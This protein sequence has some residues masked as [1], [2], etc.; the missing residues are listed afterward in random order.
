[1][2]ELAHI[3]TWKETSSTPALW[4]TQYEDLLE[5][6][7]ESVAAAK[8]EDLCILESL[9]M[10]PRDRRR[11]F[12]R[13]PQIA[14]RLLAHRPPDSFDSGPVARS[15]LAELAA[16][17]IV[18]ELPDPVWTVLGDRRLDPA[19]PTSWGKTGACIL[20]THI[21]VDGAGPTDFS[22][23][24][25]GPLVLPTEEHRV[26][27]ERK[28]SEAARAIAASSASTFGFW[29]DCVDVIAIRTTVDPLAPLS[30]NSL[31]RNA[32][33]TLI[34][35][36][37]LGRSESA[38]MAEAIVH[39][40]IHS[41]LFMFEEVHAPFVPRNSEAEFLTV[42]SP[43]SG[44]DLFLSA[45]VHACVVWYGLYWFWTA[46]AEAA[47]WPVQYCSELRARARTGFEHR[48]F[49]RLP[50]DCQK[51]LSPD[52]AGLLAEIEDRMLLARHPA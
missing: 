12:L 7:I 49:E 5:S 34:L 37:H 21:V 23:G 10:L 3:L 41:L 30:S 43:W 36:G 22:H 32:R 45:Y 2:Q 18:S 46:A 33:L 38:P 52:I 48:P 19:A 17:G 42:R 50:G 28:L 24:A 16:A 1:M 13:A 27:I 11:R 47:A 31:L 25:T 35:N 8:E 40:A 14:S 26:A 6:R 51:L 29:T 15:L 20:G 44:K 9:A 4:R 39:E